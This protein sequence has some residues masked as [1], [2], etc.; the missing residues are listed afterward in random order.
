MPSTVS[1]SPML[2]H[3]VQKGIKLFFYGVYSL[4]KLFPESCTDLF[5]WHVLKIVV[6][7]ISLLINPRP[8]NVSLYII[9]FLNSVIIVAA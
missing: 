5:T 3:K 9:T 1:I 2:L 6:M 7:K 8:N 4:I